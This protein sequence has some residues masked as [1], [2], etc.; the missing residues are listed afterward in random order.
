M[1]KLLLVVVYMNLE[2]L[3]L[4]R[5]EKELTQE[6]LAKN[7]NIGTRTSIS[8]WENG[9]EIIPLE[10]LNR[11]ANYFNVSVDYILGLTKT[12][13]YH[14]VNKELNFQLIGKRIK[15]IRHKNNLTQE[16]LARELNTTH[17]TISA[18]ENGK[19]LIKTSFIYQIAKHYHCSIDWLLGKIN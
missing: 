6:E 1:G 9:Q 5:E 4:L 11:Y 16:S 8:E 14:I 12:K 17:S 2:R 10:R 13:K 19:V 3:L 18:Y 7:L 15:E